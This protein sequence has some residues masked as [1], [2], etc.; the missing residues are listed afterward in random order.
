MNHKAVMNLVLDNGRAIFG[1]EFPATRQAG[2]CWLIQ[3]AAQG[4]PLSCRVLVQ[5]A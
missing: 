1:K 5:R 4:C 3:K 2:L